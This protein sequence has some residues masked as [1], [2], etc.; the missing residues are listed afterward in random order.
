MSALFDLTGKKALVTGGGRGLGR[1]IAVGL[2]QHGADVAVTSRTVA[3]L[4]ETA[5]A[6]GDLGRQCLAVPGDASQKAEIDRVVGEVAS[7]WGRIDILINNAGV[8]AA[9][10]AIDYTEADWDFVLDVNLKAYFFF[11]QAAA[12]VMIANGDGGA[13]ANNSSICG[14]VAVKNISAYN[15]SKGGVNM[16]TKSLALEWAPHGIRVNAFSPAYMEVFMPGAAGEHDESK[17]QAVRD[18]TPLAR[19]GKP[20]EL[21]GPVVFLV[22]NASSYVTGEVLMVDGGWTIR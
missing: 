17:E 5:D 19:R 12:K 22:S 10:P 3:E 13:I 4:N 1:A 20:E 8:D 18:L 14:E 21:V 6:V 11:A 16:L 15:I 9:A 2:A 7:Q